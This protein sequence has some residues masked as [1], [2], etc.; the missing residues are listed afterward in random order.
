MPVDVELLSTTHF[1]LCKLREPVSRWH[2]RRL[3]LLPVSCT[4]GW[5]APCFYIIDDHT[6]THA[7]R[8]K[9]R[10]QQR[11]QITTTT[12]TTTKQRLGLWTRALALGGT[13]TGR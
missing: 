12:T 2:L 3:V 9:R 5:W 11:K 13:A 1:P 6:G 10:G 8:N 4:L 7:G